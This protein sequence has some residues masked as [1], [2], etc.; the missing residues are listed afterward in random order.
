MDCRDL[1][2]KFGGH[3]MAA[4]V[5]IPKAN[6]EAFRSSMAESFKKQGATTDNRVTIDLVMPFRYVTAAL[7]E[8]LAMLE[9]FGNGNSKP[10]FAQKNVTILSMRYIG[11][12]GQFLSMKL[13]DTEGTEISGVYFGDA[14]EFVAEMEKAYGTGTADEVIAGQKTVSF[15]ICYYPDL[16]Q[17]NG[18]EYLQVQIGG[19]HFPEAKV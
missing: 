17:Y 19:Y 11:K 5:T 4:G 9:P 2:T 10:V 12:S 3:A 13:R 14:G 1:F 18:R 6:L 7:V 8:E 15:D 16:N